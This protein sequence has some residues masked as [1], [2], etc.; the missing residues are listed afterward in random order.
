[1]PHEDAAAGQQHWVAINLG[2]FQPTTARI[3]VKVWPRPQNSVW[4]E[5]YLGSALFDFMYGFGVRMQHTA[6]TFRNGVD[7]EGGEGKDVAAVYGGHVIYTG[8]F[9]GYGNLIILDHDNEYYTLYAHIADIQV[10]EG[11]DVQQGQRIGTVGDTGSLEGPRLYFEV[12]HQG[13]P[14]NPEQWLR[15]QG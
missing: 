12:R 13:K 15:Q 7:I 9:K 6:R 10:K 5:A 2:V 14:Q 8:W 1:M 11:D 4:V 3:A